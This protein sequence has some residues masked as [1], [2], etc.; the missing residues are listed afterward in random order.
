MALRQ[1]NR[2]CV[3]WWDVLDI[4]PPG[5]QGRSSTGRFQAP[6]LTWCLGLLATGCCWKQELRNAPSLKRGMIVCETRA[7]VVSGA[8]YLA[9]R[10]GGLQLASPAGPVVCLGLKRGGTEQHASPELGHRPALSGA[11]D[12]ASWAQHQTR[13]MQWPNPGGCWALQEPSAGETVQGWAGGGENCVLWEPGKWTKI[14]IKENPSSFIVPLAPST[15]TVSHLA[16]WQMRN[17]PKATATFTEQAIKGD[18]GAERQTTDNWQR[19]YT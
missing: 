13:G 16:G 12:Y 18:S 17:I 3:W 5:L 19:Q 2:C 7:G 10:W 11:P 1:R 8:S 4:T 6:G 9:W 15:G 14:E